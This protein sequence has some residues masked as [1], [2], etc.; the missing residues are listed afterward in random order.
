MSEVFLTTLPNE[1]QDTLVP[2]NDDDD[3]EIDIKS[4]TDSNEVLLTD[5]EVLDKKETQEIST[6]SIPN[7]E[8]LN[9][10]GDKIM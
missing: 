9:S 4:S 8:S 1:K 6:L 10:I 2:L 3:M 7:V 5:D